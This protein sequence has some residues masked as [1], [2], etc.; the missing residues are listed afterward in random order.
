MH[1][2]LPLV[3]VSHSIRILVGRGCLPIEGV[4]IQMGSAC[5]MTLQEGKPTMNRM[6]AKCKK[7]TFPQLRFWS[8]MILIS[9]SYSLVNKNNVHIVESK[10][11]VDCDFGDVFMCGYSS[12]TQTNS[13]FSRANGD[14][15][16]FRY[17]AEFIPGTPMFLKQV[18][19]I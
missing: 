6:S 10:M 12:F 17:K 16:Q 14:V 19:K 8:V 7:I 9:S 18:K 11:K 13:Y 1:V 5:P 4:C 15:G 3:T 2:Y